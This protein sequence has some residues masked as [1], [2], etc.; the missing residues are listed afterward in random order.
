MGQLKR[1]AIIQA[2][3]GSKR[4]PGKALKRVHGEPLLG[5]MLSRVARA[6]TLD[7]I[8]VATTTES[9][10]DPLV[11][12]CEEQGVACFRGPEH[13]VLS[14]YVQAAAAFDAE[15]I[16]RLTADCPLLDPRV[17]DLV[18]DYFAAHDFDYVSNTQDRSFPR[19]M[20][21]EVFSRS[22]LERAA[23]EATDPYHR[24]HVTAYFYDHP[25]RQL[26]MPSG[27]GGAIRGFKVGRIELRL[28]VDTEADLDLVDRILGEVGERD[29]RLADIIDLLQQNPEWVSIN[30]HLIQEE[31]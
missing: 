26:S 18:V 28:T 2:R 3:M 14:R 4:L 21:V 6:E 31:R 15:I 16:V 23:E 13:D 7:G 11:A 29:Y 19:G 12:F 20:D 27:L 5:H 8:G 30:G 22:A 25:D 1:V 17:I 9:I 24:E 10:D